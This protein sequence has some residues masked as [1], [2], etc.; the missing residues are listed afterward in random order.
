MHQPAAMQM[1]SILVHEAT[2][3]FGAIVL[4][5]SK[6]TPAEVTEEIVNMVGRP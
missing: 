2:R 4:D 6:M 1:E 3:R 5:T